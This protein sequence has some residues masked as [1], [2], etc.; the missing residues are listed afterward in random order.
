MLPAPLHFRTDVRQFS[1]YITTRCPIF[2]HVWH[3]DALSLNV[4]YDADSCTSGNGS[5]RVAWAH[6]LGAMLFDTTA[7]A[8][9]SGYLWFYRAQARL[10]SRNRA[11][12]RAKTRERAHAR[13]RSQ[14]HTD[15]GGRSEVENGMDGV[16]AMTDEGLE[17]E[18]DGKVLRFIRT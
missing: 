10:D 15:L 4:I 16:D 7:I 1:A 12:A 14:R 13:S 6:Y 5:A 3:L 2:R 18:V 11:L 9:A 17:N 8:I